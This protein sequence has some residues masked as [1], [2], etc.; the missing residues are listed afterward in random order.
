MNKTKT[1]KTKP[2]YVLVV[3][4]VQLLFFL[5]VT[6][7][8]VSSDTENL[9]TCL[10]YGDNVRV[11]YTVWIVIGFWKVQVAVLFQEDVLRVFQVHAAGCN[12]HDL[13]HLLGHLWEIRSRRFRQFNVTVHARDNVLLKIIQRTKDKVRVPAG[14][15]EVLGII[16]NIEVVHGNKF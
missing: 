16:R 1:I 11:R 8:V 7:F 10:L 3:N 14:C 5:G 15:S 2:W 4:K 12:A 13:V 9:L 6:L